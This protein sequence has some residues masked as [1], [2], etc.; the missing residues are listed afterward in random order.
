M[1][2]K[3]RPIPAPIKQDSPADRAQHEAWE[4]GELR[5][6]EYVETLDPRQREMLAPWAFS[7]E[8]RINT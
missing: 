1:K 2:A 7:D 8:S 3:E 6:L 4:A 5:H